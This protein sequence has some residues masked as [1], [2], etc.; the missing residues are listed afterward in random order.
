[1]KERTNE[2]ARTNMQL[3]REIEERKRMEEAL[4]DASQKLKI[5]AY[6][7]VHDLK[8]PAVGIYGLTR[9]LH[10]QYRESL[11]EKGRNYCDQI[12]KASEHVAAL[13]E[14]VNI[15]IAT[16]EAS[17]SLENINFKDILQI[18]RDEF[19]W[20]LNIRQIEWLQPEITIEIRA[21]RL[22]ILRVLRNLVDNSLKYGGER[23][24][25]I[26]LG[27]EESEEFHILSVSDDGKGLRD[28]D[29]KRLFRP[30]ERHETSREIEG[31][32]LGLTIVKEIVE[33]HGGKVWVE[34]RIPKGT[35]FCLSISKNL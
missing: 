25:K 26:Q 19:S 6:S 34:P 3:T 18:V 31:A 11:D 9:R 22:S 29:F 4:K 33:K 5:F 32:G 17:L 35:T 2:L 12:L 8:S 21:D 27:Y 23:L 10:K 30:F 7:V 20:Q 1:M 14:K 24:S 28:E 13:V 15:Y 16:K